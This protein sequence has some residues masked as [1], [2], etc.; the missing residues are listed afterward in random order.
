MTEEARLL[1]VDDDPGTIQ[2]LSSILSAYTDQ[3]FATNGADALRLARAAAP[4]LV[5]LDTEMQGMSGFAVCQALKADPLLSEVP[6][7]FVTSHSAPDF[8]VAA[9]KMGAADF[10]S[11]PMLPEVVRARV[12]T[13]LKVRRLTEELRRLATLDGLT[14]I[15]NRRLFD[16]TLI[17][18]WQRARRSGQPLSLLMADVDFFKAFNDLHGHQGGDKCLRQVARALQSVS[19]R[20]ADL[21]ARYGGEEFVMVLPETDSA[22]AA[23]VAHALMVAMQNLAVPHGASPLGL[24]VTLSVGLSTFDVSSGS[25]VADGVDSRFETAAPILRAADLLR[26][27]DTALYCAKKA[28]RAQVWALAIDHA[29]RADQATLCPAPLAGA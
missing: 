21:A 10:I 25:W 12:N 13:Q 16:D 5:L 27:A 3:R 1:L 19:K 7:I 26:A 9:L 4:D 8:E 29:A 18:E 22:G 11:K 24:N 28:G 23:V 14:G 15:A 17:T 6:V 20:P 2:V